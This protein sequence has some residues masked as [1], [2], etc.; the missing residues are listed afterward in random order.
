MNDFACEREKN[1]SDALRSG[2]LNPELLSHVSECATCADLVLVSQF[3]QDEARADSPPALSDASIIWRKAQLRARHEALARATWPIRMV[4]GIAAMAAF[5]ATLWLVGSVIK[6]LSWLSPAGNYRV[7][8]NYILNGEP[9]TQL[10]LIGG[11]CTLLSAGAGAVY[12][13]REDAAEARA[14]RELLS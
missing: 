2:D 12:L 3:L 8:A 7:A 9:T 13:L 1:V 4:R 14:H 6:P 10:L 5:V 11:L